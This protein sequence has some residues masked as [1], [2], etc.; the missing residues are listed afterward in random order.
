IVRLLFGLA[1]AI[2]GAAAVL[3]CD[4]NP[5]ITPAILA[6]DRPTDLAFTCYGKLRI[7]GDNKTAEA[8]DE[9]KD[10]A[11]PLES[12]RIR[13]GP[14]KTSDP[15]DDPDNAP[16]G[17]ENMDPMAPPLGPG[18]RWLGFALQPVAG[19]VTLVSAPVHGNHDPNSVDEITTQD[20]D[21]LAP[22]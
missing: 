14:P 22:G 21:K 13:T 19:T 1:L 12:C 20:S 18:H 16:L 17:Q 6:F 8:S 3:S 7:L 11:Q 2:A 10:S 5:A 9:V 15:N 4:T